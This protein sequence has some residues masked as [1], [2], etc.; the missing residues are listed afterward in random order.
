MTSFPC[1][2]EGCDK[3]FTIKRSLLDHLRHCGQTFACDICPQTYASPQS[4]NRHMKIHTSSS[5][6]SNDVAS[7]DLSSSS[8]DLSTS[9][10]TS[11][12]TSSCD[13]LPFQKVF[14]NYDFGD[15]IKKADEK[16]GKKE[17]WMTNVTLESLYFSFPLIEKFVESERAVYLSRRSH[18]ENRKISSR[19]TS[20][21]T[22]ADQRVNDLLV[23][24]RQFYSFCMKVEELSVGQLSDWLYLNEVRVMTFL[25]YKSQSCGSPSTAGNHAKILS[26]LFKFFLSCSQF[27]NFLTKVH[28]INA[29]V[30]RFRE[31]KRHEKA[32]WISSAMD[33]QSL[34][35]VGKV[36]DQ[37]D[38][39][40]LNGLFCFTMSQFVPYV[41]KLCHMAQIF[42]FQKHIV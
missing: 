9:C 15:L 4:L 12:S 3:V 26:Q 41:S 39:L 35:I 36:L 21:S 11:S 30:H 38:V 33:Y 28:H 32:K 6:S 34:F 7:L 42:F 22:S 27:E 18:E 40:E 2:K 31:Q 29:Q 19:L 25:Q 37:S 5:S 13:I 17:N 1:T 23:V 24:F 10:S 8:L 16:T 20:V 14:L